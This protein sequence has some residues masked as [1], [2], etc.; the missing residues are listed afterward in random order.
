MSNGSA[1]SGPPGHA[2]PAPDG[3]HLLDRLACFLRRYVV[4]Q[5][6]EAADFLALWVVHTHSFEAAITTPYPRITSAERESGKTRLLEVL[7][8]LVRRPWLCVTVSSAVVFRKGD[9]DAPTLLLDEIDNL[10]FTSRNELLG[11][12][13]SGYRYG[14]KVPR[15]SEKGEILEFDCFFPKAFSG[16]AGGKLPDTLHS[17]SVAVQLQ[18]RR[19][20]EPVQRFYHHHAERDAKPLRDA[21]ELWAVAHLNELVTYE[22]ELPG[23]LGDRAQ[24]VWLPLLAIGDFA[25]GEWPARAHSAAI[26]LSGLTTASATDESWGARLLGD[27]RVVFAAKGDPSAIFTHDLVAALNSD[28]EMPW[29]A[30][31]HGEG[32]RDRD[33]ARLLQP[34]AIR[35]HGI[36]TQ[37]HGEE[38]VWRG[39]R[40]RQFEEPWS[41][42]VGD[43]RYRRYSAT[44]NAPV[45]AQISHWRSEGSGVADVANHRRV[46]RKGTLLDPSDFGGPRHSNDR[47]GMSS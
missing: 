34:F 14:V 1:A 15:C 38:K 3:A 46:S 18:R 19:P 24:E 11:V 9:R 42:Y 10:D 40:R 12:L 17:R 5:Q 4:F 43:E 21:L 41:R 13:N 37:V 28:E 25:G 8:V 33:I 35:P 45:G 26:K 20:D 29:G 30:W 27:V 31:H 23:E 2:V 44:Q 6:P 22:P 39:Y 7:S 36:K 32:V 47:D 16:I